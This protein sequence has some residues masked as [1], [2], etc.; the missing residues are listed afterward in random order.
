MKRLAVGS[1]LL[2]IACTSGPRVERPTEMVVGERD[3]NR[4]VRIASGDR[5]IVRLGA[6][7]G[8]G[9]GWQIVENDPSRLEPSG[10]PDLETSKGDI[11]GGS[12]YQRF[13]FTA[14][15]PGM[16]R[17][18]LRYARPWEQKEPGARTFR[19]DVRIQ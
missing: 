1:W 15:K 18:V 19:L 8:T 5:L 11:P 9:Y 10:R 12:Q 16:V 17:L 3:A 7:L 6:Q 13:R 14:R 2:V 4:E